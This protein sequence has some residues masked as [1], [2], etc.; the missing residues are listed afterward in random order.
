[1]RCPRCRGSGTLQGSKCP[2]CGQRR[3]DD[4]TCPECGGS[5]EVEPEPELVNF[6]PIPSQV[7]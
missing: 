3:Y 4:E 6:D 5:G 7:G 2:E 1:M